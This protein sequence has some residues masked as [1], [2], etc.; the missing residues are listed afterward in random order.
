[1]TGSGVESSSSSH[2]RCGELVEVRGKEEILATLDE[3]GELHG[4]VF[5]PEMLEFCGRRMRVYRSAHKTC[6]TITKK[7]LGR[8]LE[9]CVHLEG[10][11][12]DGSEHGGCQAG[13]LFFWNDAWLKRVEPARP[14]LL[15]RAVSA[16][17]D[18]RPAG[19]TGGGVRTEDELRA[20]T[21][22]E[23]ASGSADPTYE[24]QITRLLDATAPLPWWEPMQY[25]RDWTSGNVSLGMLLR[26]GFLRILYRLVIFSK[27][28]RFK[29]KV[30]NAFAKLLGEPPYPYTAGTLTGK[31]PT[32][33]LDLQPGELVRVRS[34][35]EIL[36]T[37]KGRKNRGLGFSPEMVRYC[38]G[39][40]RVRSRVKNIIDEATGKMMNFGN[41]CIILDDV[42]CRSE[43]SSRRLFCPRSIY[44]YW[45]E[46]WLERVN[47]NGSPGAQSS[48][49]SG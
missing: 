39:T 21:T 15:W 9:N 10:A 42:V 48:E 13:C 17:G 16:G 6:D 11:R 33:Q 49:S 35:E 25:V 38:G 12:C 45:R 46:I 3:R 41:E 28:Y 7:N 20:L 34:H 31:T 47:E 36:Q 44:P 43:C 8:R 19:R 4:L 18:A 24:C 23:D 14:S 5:M 26:N 37:L 22:V 30:Y 29:V 40:Y 27:G 1:M 32:R 2:L